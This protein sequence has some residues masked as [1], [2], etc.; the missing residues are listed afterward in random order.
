MR[1]LSL[2]LLIIVQSFLSSCSSRSYTTFNE[3]IENIK[4]SSQSRK[5]ISKYQEIPR[6]KSL[7]YKMSPGFLFYLNH[8]SDSKL[9]GR[10]R[11]DFDGFLRLPYNVRV[12]VK[13]LTFRELRDKVLDSYSKF[14]Q[15]GVGNVQF[16]LVYKQYYVEIRGFVKKT[17]R[18]LVSR[19]ESIDKVIDKAGGV[20]GDLEKNFYKASIEQQGSSYSI[21]LNQFYQNNSYRNSFR[22]TGGDSIFISEQDE[23][24][25]GADLPLVTV[26]GG[27]LSPG[28]TLYKDNA[29]LFYYL[30]KS[31]GTVPSIAYTESYIIREKNDKIIKIQFDLTDM[32]AI[33]AIEASD[34][35]L[36]QASKE[37]ALDKFFQRTSQVASI[38]LTALLIMA[39]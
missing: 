19:N 16:S 15:R 30:G 29:H 7:Q 10:Y 17:G 3:E 6:H 9:K 26:L 39:L 27:V 33:P 5:I 31:G 8:P 20:K 35:I 13:G 36:L 24:E 25:M 21:S 34:I 1:F 23:S 2:L 4:K 18:Y 22:W 14:F 11:A 28:K 38:I 32:S 37:T 12:N